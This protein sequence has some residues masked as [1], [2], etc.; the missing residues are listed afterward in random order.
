MSGKHILT[1]RPYR[2]LWYADTASQLGIALYY[3]ANVFMVY[4]LTGQ[5]AMVGYNGALEA[6]PFFIFGPYSGV[7]ADRFD[8]R[9]V[10]LVAGLFSGTCLLAL[11]VITWMY[12]GVTPVA[13]IL[14]TSF[15]SCTGRAFFYPARNASVPRLVPTNRAMDA[16]IWSAVSQNFVFSAGQA[17][18][19]TLI[20]GLYVVSREYFYLAAVLV[21]GASYFVSVFFVARLP[22]IIP[23]A[24][25]APQRAFTDVKAGFGY[26]RKRKDLVV[27][28]WVIVVANFMIAPFFPCYVKANSLWF[29]GRPQSLAWIEFSFFVPTIFT[30]LALMRWKMRHMGWGNIIGWSGIGFAVAA[31]SFIRTVKGWCALNASCG[32]V[33]PLAWIPTDTYLQVTVP[34]E[35]RGRVQSARTMLSAGIQPIGLALGGVLIDSLGLPAVLQI[36]GWGM[37]AAG[38][39]GVCSHAFRNAITPDDAEF[40]GPPLTGFDLPIEAEA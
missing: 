23:E 31:M 7:V 21:N 16:N 22:Q 12:R 3:I 38:V 33:G 4:R 20:A 8:R 6:L 11:G 9:K 24:E 37:V 13:A 1:Y 35:F 29:D 30:G 32:L 19:A 25:T 17:L 27:L 10:M 18:S 40:P 15:L 26:I 2:L 39:V 14:V 34:D 5:A 28:L 36:M